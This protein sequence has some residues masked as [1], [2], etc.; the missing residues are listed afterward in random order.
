MERFERSVLS[1]SLVHVI[2][3]RLADSVWNVP[4]SLG[5]EYRTSSILKRFTPIVGIGMTYIVSRISENIHFVHD[6]D[7][8]WFDNTIALHSDNVYGIYT[9]V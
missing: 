8:P 2:R 3:G 4:I 1:V 6:G 7:P 5:Y 9:K